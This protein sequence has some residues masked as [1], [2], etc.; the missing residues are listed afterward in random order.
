MGSFAGATTWRLR[1]KELD[2]DKKQ[3]EEY[4][5][6]EYKQLKKLTNVKTS[7]DRS[8]CLHCSYQL[9]WFDL[10]PLVSWVSLKGKCRKCRQPIGYFEPLMELGVAL[11][12]VLSFAF[13]PGQLISAL[14]ITHF[15][16]WLVAG[17]ALAILFA[18]DTKWFMLP[19]KLN[20]ALI[21]LG[22]IVSVIT[23]TTSTNPADA[24]GSIAGSIAI[25]S[26]MYYVIYLVSHGK[27]IGFGD[28]KLGLGLALLL[29]DWQLA[30]IALFVANL[31]GC[32]IVI[33]LMA[34]G[35]LKRNS[36]V[37]FGPLLIIGTIVAFLAGA[38]LLNWYS[39]LVLI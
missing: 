29:A 5:A 31:V 14:Q 15:V 35:K 18:Y 23:V 19:D 1:A 22:L 37:P 36:H 27:W 9:R 34:I 11:Y 20:Y 21:G 4:D 16:V 3:G 17:V 28:I 30:F 2:D 13:W 10:I 39:G 8:V 26:G 7:Q 6:T 12:F 24:V 25:L 38:A 32:L 33:P